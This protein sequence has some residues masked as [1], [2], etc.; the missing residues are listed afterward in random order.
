MDKVSHWSVT[1]KWHSTPAR[2]HTVSPQVLAINQSNPLL[3]IAT[4]RHTVPWIPWL[5]ICHKLSWEYHVTNVVSIAILHHGVF[6][7]SK[8]FLSYTEL[9]LVYNA[10]TQNYMESSW[11]STMSSCS[12]FPPFFSWGGSQPG[13]PHNWYLK[14][15]GRFLRTVTLP[16][17]A[18][19][20]LYFIQVNIWPCSS[21]LLPLQVTCSSWNCLL[22]SLP[23]SRLDTHLHFSST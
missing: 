7:Q 1:L 11:L 4:G 19:C 2:S 15:G 18:S 20:V 22:L 8:I 13:F 6:H 16:L 21:C 17:A 10:F 12:C 3:W 14:A 5:T 23:K 9:N